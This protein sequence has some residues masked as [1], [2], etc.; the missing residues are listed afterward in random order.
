MIHIDQSERRYMIL[1]IALLV[2]FGIALTVGSLAYGIQLVRPELQVNPAL[3]TTPGAY[4][5]YD[6]FAMPIEERVLELAPG[7]YAAYIMGYATKGWKFEPNEVRIPAGSEVTF[8]VTSGDV[9]HGFMVQNTNINMMVIPGQISKLTATF[10][11]PGIYNFICHEYCGVAHH[12]M[13]GRI[14]VE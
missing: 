9:I 11:E 1:T 12:T 8:Y 4:P 5:E 6:G 7:Q 14:I 10:D 3:I 13:Y 2:I